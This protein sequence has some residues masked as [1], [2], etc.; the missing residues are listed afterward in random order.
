R[1]KRQSCVLLC[2]GRG[3]EIGDWRLEIGDWGVAG[4]FLILPPGLE[5]LPPGN[6]GRGL[7]ASAAHCY[8][9]Q[10]HWPRSNGTFV[11]NPQPLVPPYRRFAHCAATPPGQSPAPAPAVA[12][13][14]SAPAPPPSAK[15]AGC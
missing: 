7:V 2:V 1:F 8:C 14:G 5:S 13:R 11:T 15:A 3:L 4:V 6:G 10:S 9:P 12:T